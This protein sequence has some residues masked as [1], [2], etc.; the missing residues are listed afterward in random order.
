MANSCQHLQTLTAIQ[1][2]QDSLPPQVSLQKP[3]IFLDALHRLAPIH[4]E[5]INSQEAFL[6]GLKVRFKHV[7]L[8]MIEDGRFALEATATKRDINLDRPWEVCFYAGQ[9]YD[10]SMLFQDASSISATICMACHYTCSGTAGED[11]PW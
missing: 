4:L 11:I 1:K 7:G 5:R 9:A 10:M 6:A 2:I 3:V 8:R